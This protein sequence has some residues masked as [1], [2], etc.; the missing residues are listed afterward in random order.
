M[1]NPTGLLS[2][3]YLNPCAPHHAPSIP[4]SIIPGLQACLKCGNEFMDDSVFCRKCGSERAKQPP[5]PTGRRQSA[6]GKR[7]EEAREDNPE[8]EEQRAIRKR[9]QAKLRAKRL[10]ELRAIKRKREEDEAREK[11]AEE[12]RRARSADIKGQLAAQRKRDHERLLAD[13]AA[14]QQVSGGIGTTDISDLHAAVMVQKELIVSNFLSMSSCSAG[15][16]ADY[17]HQKE[18]E[19]NPEKPARSAPEASTA[20]KPFWEREDTTHEVINHCVNKYP[21]EQR[22][23]ARDVSICYASMHLC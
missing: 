1:C 7:V 11:A 9:Q 18:I 15:L 10:E 13:R 19:A 16:Q 4:K 3:V 2:L 21:H 6:V 12:N 14:K 8:T 5:V 17:E 23:M 20:K 22:L